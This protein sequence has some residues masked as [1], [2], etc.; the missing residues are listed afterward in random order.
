MVIILIGL[1]HGGFVL[2]L[3]DL[4]L[5]RISNEGLVGTNTL[6]MRYRPAERCKEW[7]FNFLSSLD[8][9]LSLSMP[10]W[11]E[12]SMIN[13]HF[14]NKLFISHIHSS[15]HHDIWRIKNFALSNFSLWENV[16]R[17]NNTY[18]PLWRRSPLRMHAFYEI[19]RNLY[20][21]N[22]V[23]LQTQFFKYLIKHTRSL[24]AIERGK[25]LCLY[26]PIPSNNWSP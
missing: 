22:K 15:T 24:K 18:A 26:S 3:L 6:T 19:C 12:E 9:F 21:Q 16:G 13:K 5:H 8:L 20:T 1:I 10:F 14:G 11:V 2:C 7:N 23:I 25:I 17:M 4:L